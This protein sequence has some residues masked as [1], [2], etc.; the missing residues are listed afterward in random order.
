MGVDQINLLLLQKIAEL[1]VTP[2]PLERVVGI[3]VNLCE[4]AQPTRL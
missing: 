1:L 2:E 4:N 3:E